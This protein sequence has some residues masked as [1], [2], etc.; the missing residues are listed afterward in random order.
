MTLLLPL[1]L[2]CRGPS[3]PAGDAAEPS[4]SSVPAA[5][6]AT[7]TALPSTGLPTGQTVL[8]ATTGTGETGAT[9]STGDTGHPPFEYDDRGC[10]TNAHRSTEVMYLDIN[11]LEASVQDPNA[12]DEWL[13]IRMS[14]YVN[15]H[16]VYDGRV[17]I[18]VKAAPGDECQWIAGVTAIDGDLVDAGTISIDM[19]PHSFEFPYMPPGSVSYPTKTAGRG[20]QG[21]EGY[22][23]GYHEYF[24]Y[25]LP[26]VIDPYFGH[27]VEVT[28]EGSAELA[29]FTFTGQMPPQ[30]LEILEPVHETY[31]DVDTHV[32]RWVPG[33][34]LDG[35]LLLW[36][37]ADNV[38]YVLECYTDDDGE[39]RL[40]QALIDELEPG[41]SGVG[42]AFYTQDTCFYDVGDGR[43]V[44]ANLPRHTESRR[45]YFDLPP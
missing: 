15:S 42:V 36:V 10:V 26:P 4:D 24:A 27:D 38:D 19:G 29:G 1:L 32:Y 34:A 22:G 21:Y 30:R 41:V 8:T 20:T 6:T 40:P 31:W 11:L 3:A 23:E 43:T 44:F 5:A 16:V 12:L 17:E 9:G 25:G 45:N 2:A 33:A 18:P 14:A 13:S 28:V 7:D 39:W 35:R 37:Y